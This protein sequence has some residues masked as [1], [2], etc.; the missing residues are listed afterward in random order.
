VVDGNVA[1]Y[2]GGGVEK[3]SGLQETTV[4]GMCTT[5]GPGNRPPKKGGRQDGTP[6]PARGG[7]VSNAGMK[8]SGTAK[9]SGN[10]RC[11]Q[12]K[13]KGGWGPHVMGRPWHL[14]A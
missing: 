12:R 9:G 14:K 1:E 3:T 5:D 2:K 10:V 13:N 11:K 8:G 4:E 6:K 7:P